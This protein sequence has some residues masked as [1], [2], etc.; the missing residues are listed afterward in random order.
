MT[1]PEFKARLAAQMGSYWLSERAGRA[2]CVQ[3]WKLRQIFKRDR[4]V[5]LDLVDK[6]LQL[7]AT[8][9]DQRELLWRHWDCR[10]DLHPLAELHR[11]YDLDERLRQPPNLARQIKIYNRRRALTKRQLLR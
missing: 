10:T 4:D 6:L 1:G 3:A 7:E 11:A 5:A 8:P 9:H 2:F